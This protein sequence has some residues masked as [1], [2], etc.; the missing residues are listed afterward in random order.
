MAHLLCYKE[1][2][3]K[4]VTGGGVS[5][6]KRYDVFKAYVIGGGKTYEKEAVKGVTGGGG[7]YKFKGYGFR[8]YV[9][10][11]GKHLLT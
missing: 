1:E 10:G 8:A 7:V 5:K 6:F 11:D 3:G 2:A 4:G 9:T